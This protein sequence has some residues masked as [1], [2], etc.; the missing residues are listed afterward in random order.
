MKTIYRYIAIVGTL[1]SFYSNSYAM[2]SSN[3]YTKTISATGHADVTVPQTIATISFSISK[4]DDNAKDVQQSVKISADKL[5]GQLKAT[6][7][8]SVQTVGMSVTPVMS[9]KDNT[10]KV[11]GYTA[12]YTVEVKSKITD[13]G[14]I[15]DKAM[16]NGVN[17]MNS[18]QLSASDEEKSKA[19]LEAIRI[20]TL[21]AKSQADISLNA[22]GL[23]SNVIKQIIVSPNQNPSPQ[24]RVMLMRTSANSAPTTPIEAGVDTISADVNIVVGY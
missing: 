13:A 3:L 10:S 15:M 21:N 5:V 6:N 16:D 11:I 4:T 2:D 20:A 22:L 19:Q 14:K 7:P 12:T 17:I 23:K 8:I 1:T 9:Y 24:P 18:P